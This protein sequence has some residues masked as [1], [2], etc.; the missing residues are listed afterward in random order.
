MANDIVWFDSSEVGAPVLNNVAGSLDSVMNAC[1]VTGFRPLTLDSIVVSSSVATATYS[2]GHGYATGRMLDIGGAAAGAINGRKLVTVTGSA[3]FTFPAPGVADGAVGGVITAKRSP[4]GW[5]RPL[6]SGNVS[7]YARTEVTATGMALRVDDSGSGAASAT[8][9]RWRMVE[10][11]TD[12]STFTGPTPRAAQFGGAGVYVPKGSDNA[13]PKKWVLVGDSRGFYLFTEASGYPAASYGSVPQGVWAFGDIEPYRS[14]DAYA[15][16][17]A[18]SQSDA[19]VNAQGL[20][21]LIPPGLGPTDYH[22]MLPRPFNAI[23]SPVRASAVGLSP[24]NRKMGGG[25]PAYPSPVDNGVIISTP[26][27]VVEENSAFATP[28]R[29]QL[30]GVGDPVAT[31]PGGLLHLT[32]LDNLTGSDR[33]WLLVG[34]NQQGSYGHMAFDITGP[35]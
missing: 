22:T 2:A 24:G 17:L 32:T 23:G 26:V 13:D 15:C 12:L 20:G 21:N 25:G 33:R 7:M 8:A 28:F 1:L 10:G 14:G 31:I 18:G 16:L 34:F 19:G 27:L 9:A 29:G 5:A 30:R 35:W 11:Y 4:L 6:S 3:T